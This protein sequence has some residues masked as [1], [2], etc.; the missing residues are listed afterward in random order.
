MQLQRKQD[1][2]PE[3]ARTG[4]S[5]AAVPQ[6][7][8]RTQGAVRKQGHFQGT[9]NCGDRGT[10]LGHRG[11]CEDT[12]VLGGHGETVRTRGNSEYTVEL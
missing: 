4:E 2:L 11:R 12:G 10:L 1:G 5:E 9:G 8:L 7:N 6:R 3:T